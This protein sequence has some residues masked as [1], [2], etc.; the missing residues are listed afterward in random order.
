LFFS[1]VLAFSIDLWRPF[2]GRPIWRLLL[3]A[4]LLG[5]F[6]PPSAR[7]ISEVGFGLLPSVLFVAVACLLVIYFLRNNYLA[8]FLSAA[9]VSLARASLPLTVQGNTLLAIQG[10]L[11]WALLLGGMIW[12]WRQHQPEANQGLAQE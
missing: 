9:V 7:R 1:A 5:S 12:L 2:A 4:G 11:L 8:Y 10:C 6:L 3:L